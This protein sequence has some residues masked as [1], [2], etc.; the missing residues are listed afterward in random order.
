M[1][2]IRLIDNDYMSREDP[3][4]T[5]YHCASLYKNLMSVLYIYM[6]YLSWSSTVVINV[7]SFVVKV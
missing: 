4:P 3:I 5:N 7:Q 2:F 6:F 1:K